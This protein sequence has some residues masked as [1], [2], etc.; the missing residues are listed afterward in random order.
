M[1]HV[2]LEDAIQLAAI[3]CQK[4]NTSAPSGISLGEVHKLARR[5]G[6]SIRD[7]E[8][9]ALKMGVLP[10]RYRRSYGT[11]G[12]HGQIALLESCVAVVGAG[13]LGGY[14]IEGLARMGIGKLII[15]DGDTF[16]ESNLNRQLGC[17]E[18]TLGMPKASVLAE[19]VR[20]INSA[21]EP[22][23]LIV[24]FEELNARELLTG[25]Q[26]V[27]DALDSLP[28][29]LLLQRAAQAL[30]IPMVH[31]AIAGHT[32][33]VMTIMPDDVGLPALYG[34]TPRSAHGVEQVLGN[35]AATPMLVAAWQIA[36]VVQLLIGS[37]GPARRMLLFDL[38]YGESTEV[39]V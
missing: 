22:L 5:F 39:L 6:L 35:P 14:I 15:I 38:E 33:Q 7:V 3:P 36:Q 23:A 34:D 16:S 12:L 32:G 31:G 20:R 4:A 19:R 27:A 2:D 28:S 11:L 24:S 13:G 10:E 18:D 9:R 25:A 30:R 26:V 8:L 29:R 37:Q 17:T 1:G 21:V